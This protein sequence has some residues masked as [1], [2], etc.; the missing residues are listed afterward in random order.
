MRDL[1]SPLLPRH[2]VSGLV[3]LSPQT[4]R[5]WEAFGIPARAGRRPGSRLYSWREVDQLQRA[6]YFIKTRRRSLA[7]VR[8]LLMRHT[9]TGAETVWLITRAKP[10]VRPRRRGEVVAVTLPR[11]ARRRGQR[12]RS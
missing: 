12:R 9:P 2:I 6:A 1:E 3:G 5:R 7:E 10:P 8:R 4:L 11:S